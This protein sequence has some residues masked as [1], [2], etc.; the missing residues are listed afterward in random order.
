MACVSVRKNKVAEVSVGAPH[1]VCRALAPIQTTRHVRCVGTA[2]T[3]NT[4]LGR[5][6]ATYDLP[7][8][9]LESV[10]TVKTLSRKLSC[11]E[12]GYDLRDVRLAQM[13]A[14]IVLRLLWHDA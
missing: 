2:K 9:D 1:V 14:C 11:H 8:V 3:L 6:E 4:K 7:D 5:H 13:V 10:D 12:A